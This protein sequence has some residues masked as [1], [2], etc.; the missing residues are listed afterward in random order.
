MPITGNESCPMCRYDLTGLPCPHLCP[1]CGSPFDEFTRSWHARKPWKM[2]LGFLGS[3]YILTDVS[4]NLATGSHRGY[5]TFAMICGLLI[6]YFLVVS[7]II[8][9]NRRGRR[10]AVT[11]SGILVSQM[12]EPFVIAWNDIVDL[13]PMSFKRV[14]V[15]RAGAIMPL[16]VGNI[17]ESREEAAAFCEYALRCKAMYLSRPTEAQTPRPPTDPSTPV[18]A[19]SAGA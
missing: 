4:V 7:S 17:F 9:A 12:K 5:R 15:E 3:I 11:P 14:R 1:E 8:R 2:Y 10:V 13:K 18:A 19:T 6:Y 16:D